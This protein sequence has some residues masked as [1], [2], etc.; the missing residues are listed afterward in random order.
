MLK[1][2]TLGLL[3]LT[4]TTT[5]LSEEAILL[6][7]PTGQLIGIV[8]TSNGPIILTKVT[9]LDLPGPGPVTPDPIQLPITKAVVLME[10]GDTTIETTIARAAVRNNQKISPKVFFL[11]PDTKDE[12]NQP[13]KLVTTIKA[14]IK[15]KPLPVVVG[16]G[17]GDKPLRVEAFDK[18]I[19]NLLSTW[20]I[21]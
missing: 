18:D 21:K 11:D 5:T 8:Q 20:G 15:D 14:F 10:S 12:N 19:I 6:K 9:I 2:M 17:D 13:D 16:L 4:L 1:R 3:L 7:L